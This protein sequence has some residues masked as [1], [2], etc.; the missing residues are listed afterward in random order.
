MQTRSSNPEKAL[1]KCFV[2]DDEQAA[3]DKLESFIKITSGLEFSGSEKDPLNSQAMLSI[4]KELPDII[5]LD[6]EMKGPTG[7]RLARM[8]M[9]KTLI[10]FTT[11]HTQ[12]AVEAYR[13]NAVDYLM[14][15]I[16]YPI[17]LE[18][19]AKCRFRKE[20][21]DHTDKD[22]ANLLFIKD[23]LSGKVIKVSQHEIAYIQSIGN[24]CKVCLTGKPQ[25]MPHVSLRQILSQLR[26]DL[27]VRIHKSYA[28]NLKYIRFYD[29]NGTVQLSNEMKLEVGRTF[30]KKLKEKIKLTHGR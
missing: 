20:S 12:F 30:K 10:V 4:E 7:L 19:I 6:I 2:I 14:K 16:T 26:T 11:G 24:Y 23:S 22:D 17:F 5:F 29:G 3:I 25:I 9:D 28:V 8:V 15:P 1:L 13:L 18:A 21:A 27:F